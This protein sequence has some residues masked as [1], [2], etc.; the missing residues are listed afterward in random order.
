LSA[1]ANT[2][3]LADRRTLSP[4]ASVGSNRMRVISWR[5]KVAVACSVHVFPASVERSTPLP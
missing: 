2:P 4:V 3:L 5:A 1:L